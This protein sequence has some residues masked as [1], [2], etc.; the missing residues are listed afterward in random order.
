MSNRLS[1]EQEACLRSGADYEE[2]YA[3]LL[4]FLAVAG[5]WD[6]FHALEGVIGQADRLAWGVLRL[7]YEPD[8]AAAERLCGRVSLAADPWLAWTL[9]K[10]ALARGQSDWARAIAEARTADSGR[11]VAVWNLIARHCAARGDVP[12]ALDALDA[13]LESN[14][15]QDHLAKLRGRLRAGEPSGMPP[16]DLSLVPATEAVSLCIACADGGAGFAEALDG[17]LAQAHPLGAVYAAGQAPPHAAVERHVTVLPGTLREGLRA[18]FTQSNTPWAGYVSEAVAL[19]PGYVKCCL[20]AWEN[21]PAQTG[22]LGGRLIE[23]YTDTPADAWRAAHLAQDFGNLL[24]VDPPALHEHSGLYRR[25]AVL[26][27]NNVPADAATPEWTV[28][29]GEALQRAGYRQLYVPDALA[30]HLRRDTTASVLRRKWRWCRPLRESR[31]D[32]A[33]GAAW[34]SALPH[35]LST[36][37]ALLNKDIDAG[38]ANLIY[39]D[40][41]SFFAEAALDARILVEKQLVAPGEAAYISEALLAGV[42]Y[43]DDVYGGALRPAVAA[44][45]ADLGTTPDTPATSTRHEE[46]LRDL[47]AQLYATLDT[48]DDRVYRFLCASAASTR[49]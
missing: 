39:L 28:A 25:K 22:A 23:A 6:D 32:Y 35:A 48:V 41:L 5:R 10:Y 21:G 14:P 8:D 12:G 27:A 1:Q 49:A 45:L 13:T 19:A 46:A 26:R 40:F 7:A 3:D 38:A 20:M 44:D 36:M 16:P 2:H 11:D 43:L 24:L 29:L 31:G 15:H 4:Y 9:A 33:D 37:V 17:V 47:L 30:R 42:E 34:L 18:Y